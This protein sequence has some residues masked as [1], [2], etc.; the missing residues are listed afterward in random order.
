M[1]GEWGFVSKSE[2]G[3]IFE[4]IQTQKTTSEWNRYY[5]ILKALD[6]LDSWRVAALMINR[7]T[8]P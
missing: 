2:K 1:Y 5:Q 6:L 7:P 8:K 3:V 4:I